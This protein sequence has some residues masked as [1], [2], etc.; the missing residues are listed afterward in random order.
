MHNDE[1]LTLTF[2][3]VG[4]NWC[5][6]SVSPLQA[7]GPAMIFTSIGII[8]SP[9]AGKSRLGR[10][11]KSETAVYPSACFRSKILPN[12]NASRSIS[13]ACSDPWFLATYGGILWR[14]TCVY[15]FQFLGRS[16]E[17]PVVI[18]ILSRHTMSKNMGRLGSE[19]NMN[20]GVSREFL[21]GSEKLLKVQG[22][23]PPPTSEPSS[24]D[25]FNCCLQTPIAKFNHTLYS[26]ERNGRVRSSKIVNGPV[27]HR[28]C[29]F[30]TALEAMPK[31]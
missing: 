29:L 13:I 23:R 8:L 16:L 21:K 3:G 10:F 28:S 17:F 30:G 22:L 9:Y 24:S 31:H 14:K 1:A 12:I 2:W 20:G 19:A 26:V 25:I 18:G 7:F 27:F 6:W 5:L 4:P 11:K 15:G